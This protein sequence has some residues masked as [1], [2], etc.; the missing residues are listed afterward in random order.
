M[1]PLLLPVTAASLLTAA[2]M[3]FGF[4]TLLFF[5]SLI[6]PGLERSGYPLQNGETIDYK[7]TGMTLFFLLHI[8]VG[9]ATFGFGI[10]L[11]PIVHYFWSLVI[12]A[13]VVAIAWSLVLYNRGRRR[14]FVMKSEFGQGSKSASW[15]ADMWFG[16]ELNPAWLGVDLKMFMYQPSLL[17]VYLVVLSFAYAQYER[18]G[19]V[20]PQ[21]WCFVGFWFA[22][23]FT[24][25][26]KEEFMLSTWDII[27]ENFGLMLV[28]GDLVYV[29]FFYAL[30]G[31]WIVDQTTPFTTI[32]W[33]GLTAFFLISLSIFRGANWQKSRFKQNPHATFWG[34]PAR[35]I[36][37]RLLASG[38]WG[39]GRKLNYTG[40]VG[41]Y[42]SFALCAGLSHWQPFILP[43]SL[44][45][46]LTQ[47]AARDDKKCRA[48]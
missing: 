15:A 45:G 3:V 44:L 22:Y 20:L 18:H 12:V 34:R 1:E 28:W 41:V 29:P 24:H 11:A 2:V 47:R 21:T 48:K 19:I 7:L 8:V 36:G 16:N 38:W 9:V 37:G 35:T 32:Q 40:E 13:T 42:L 26:V 30:P 6:M 23:L 5:G 31:F 39:I 43:L 33:M 46:L 27:A 14:G 4:I 10:S 17:G 25:Y